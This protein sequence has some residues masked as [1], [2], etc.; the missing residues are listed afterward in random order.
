VI[1]SEP[2]LEGIYADLIESPPSSSNS[3]ELLGSITSP[4]EFSDGN[5]DEEASETLVRD[6]I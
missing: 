4:R 1:R 3:M 5:F 6:T 2:D